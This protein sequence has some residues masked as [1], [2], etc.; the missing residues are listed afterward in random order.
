MGVKKSSQSQIKLKS[1]YFQPMCIIYVKKVKFNWLNRTAVKV[2]AFQKTIIVRRI[3][4]FFFNRRQQVYDNFLLFKPLIENKHKSGWLL[5]F[6]FLTS[7][8]LMFMP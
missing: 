3:F 5:N 6:L 4:G 7:V 8:E 2:F 1:Y